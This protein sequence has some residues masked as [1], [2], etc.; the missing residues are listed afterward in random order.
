MGV[1]AIHLHLYVLI[2]D[3][4]LLWNRYILPRQ[5]EL[6]YCFRCGLEESGIVVSEEDLPGVKCFKRE[7]PKNNSKSKPGFRTKHCNPIKV[8]PAESCHKV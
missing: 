2:F 3:C 7:K 4:W 6:G 8:P 5:Q 1:I